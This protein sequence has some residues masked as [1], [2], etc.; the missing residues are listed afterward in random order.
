MQFLFI[1]IQFSLV[2]WLSFFSSKISLPRYAP[3]MRWFWFFDKIYLFYLQFLMFLYYSLYFLFV[4]FGIFRFYLYSSSFLPI[5]FFFLTLV[6]SLSVSSLQYPANLPLFQL[7]LP[8]ATSIRHLPSVSMTKLF[9]I[10]K[11]V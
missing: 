5:F 8:I 10:L 6:S 11:L 4:L 1:F 9:L 2:S 7:H 3:L